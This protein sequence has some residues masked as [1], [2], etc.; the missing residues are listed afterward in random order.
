MK[1]GEKRSM[2]QT[3][4]ARKEGGRKSTTL[5]KWRNG[6]GNGDGIKGGFDE[7]AAC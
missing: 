1:D 3:N 5:R 2:D 6:T 4:K 7:R